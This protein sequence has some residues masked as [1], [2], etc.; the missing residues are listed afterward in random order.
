MLELWAINTKEVYMLKAIL[1]DLDHTLIDWSEAESWD[2]FLRRRFDPVWDFVHEN[3]HPLYD[4]T[5]EDMQVSFSFMLRT[6]WRIG[7]R[8]LIAPNFLYV[9]RETLTTIGVSPEQ[10]DV[11]EIMRIFDWQPMQGERAYPDALEVLPQ[12]AAQGVE[13]G[14]V[15][16]ASAPMRYRDQELAAFDLLGYFPR[17]RIAATEVGYLKPHRAIFQRALELLGV[18]PHEVVFVGDNLE[19]DIKGAQQA[20]MVAVLRAHE[21]VVDEWASDAPEITPDGTI[22]TLHEL[23]ALLDGWFP[24]WRHNGRNGHGGAA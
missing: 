14:L 17:C 9:L 1:F 2:T 18:A 11:P 4:A 15:T 10:V 12:L 3:M 19:A 5:A 24:G 21:G 20:G 22:H 6:A 13:L 16:N 23:P 8:T 7:T